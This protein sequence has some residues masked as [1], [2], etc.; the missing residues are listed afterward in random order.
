MAEQVETPPLALVDAAVRAA[1]FV[2]FDKAATAIVSSGRCFVLLLEEND[3]AA[4]AGVIETVKRSIDAAECTVPVVVAHTDKDSKKIRKAMSLFNALPQCLVYV[5]SFT[6][7]RLF[8]APISCTDTL[9]C[10]SV[11]PLSSDA[12]FRVFI[13]SSLA[14]ELKKGKQGCRESDA[15]CESGVSTAVLE[16]AATRIFQPT[17]DVLVLF[18]T[19]K[20]PLCPAARDVL[21]SVFEAVRA[22]QPMSASCTR[23]PLCACMYNIERNDVVGAPMCSDEQRAKAEQVT[24]VPHFRLYLHGCKEEPVAFTG[25]RSCDALVDFLQT[26]LCGRPTAVSFK[27]VRQKLGLQ[28]MDAECEGE[29]CCQPQECCPF[30]PKRRRD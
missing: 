9:K 13:E 11:D 26:Q 22:C 29:P 27:L 4:C 5:H 23:V 14:G 8:V 17:A 21:V 25:D 12:D 24:G 3:P 10:A 18:V 20:C 19:D 6:E 1:R 7:G 30:V 16:T 15:A 28:P 2:A